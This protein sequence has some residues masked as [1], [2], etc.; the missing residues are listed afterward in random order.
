MPFKKIIASLSLAGTGI[1]LW[2]CHMS[3]VLSTVGKTRVRIGFLLGVNRLHYFIL[4][5]KIIAGLLI[6]AGFMVAA[7]NLHNVTSRKK[8]KIDP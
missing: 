7:R 4:G 8:D 1:V 3:V 2:L 5:I 6:L